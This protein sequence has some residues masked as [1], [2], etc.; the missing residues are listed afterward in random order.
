MPVPLC[1]LSGVVKIFAS[2]DLV[3][4]ISFLDGHYLLSYFANK[5]D[6][7]PAEAN[8]IEDVAVEIGLTVLERTPFDT[9]FI[10]SIVQGQTILEYDTESEAGEAVKKIWGKTSEILEINK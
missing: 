5:F 9:V 4:N 3:K 7:N 6:L 10:R 8:N 1:I 2:L